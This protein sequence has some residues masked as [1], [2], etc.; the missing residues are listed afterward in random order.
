MGRDPEGPHSAAPTL[1]L[2]GQTASSFQLEPSGFHDPCRQAP[3]TL[4]KDTPGL[5]FPS[6][7]KER[8][9]RAPCFLSARLGVSSAIVGASDSKSLGPLCCGT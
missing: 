5:S 1:T 3:L 9:L 7:R 4:V 6:G 8:L 2:S